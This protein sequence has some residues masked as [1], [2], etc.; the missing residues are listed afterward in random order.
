MP[1]GPAQQEQAAALETA[2]LA[3]SDIDYIE[4]H[5]TGTSLGDPIELDALSAVYGDRKD[6]APLIS[7]SGQE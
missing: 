6:A 2:R 3:P 7:S 1:N 5:G 4:A